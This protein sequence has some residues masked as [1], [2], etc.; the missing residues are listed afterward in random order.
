VDPISGNGSAPHFAVDASGKV[1]VSN[2]GFGNGRLYSFNPDLTLRWS[3]AVNNVNQGGPALGAD[4]TLV[5][6]GVG[7]NVRAF[8]SACQTQATV[9]SRNAGANPASLESNLPI[10]GSTWTAT[11]DLSTTGH[12]MAS[13]FAFDGATDIPLRHGQRLL[14][15]NL[16]GSG[17][18]FLA[19]QGGPLATFSIPVPLDLTLCGYTL[20]VQA[21]HF[22][23]P[24]VF[25]LSNALDL[26][27]GG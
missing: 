19:M 6:A 5:I 7:G 9:A 10:L 23:G 3:L 22:G 12:T 1:F 4:G 13:L 11:V 17:R 2:G 15:A 18:L 25:A 27:L 21:A 20:C 14:C 26:V 24:P 16:S 8:R